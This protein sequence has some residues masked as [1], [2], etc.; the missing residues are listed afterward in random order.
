MKKCFT[1]A[2]GSTHVATPKN[3]RKKAFT[4]AEVL[5]TLGI[6]GVVAA[7]TIPVLISNYRDRQYVTAFKKSVSV[8]ANAYNL[9]I[10]ENGGTNDFGYL[11]A[12]YV[13][14]PE[15][16]GS[17][18]YNK[19]SN[20]NSD[21]LFKALSKHLNIIKDCGQDGKDG[22]FPET[23]YSP[24]RDKTWNIIHTQ[25]NSRRFFVLSD[26]TAVGLTSGFAYIDT[27][28]LKKPN[29]LGVDVFQVQFGTNS[30]SFYD[31]GE[32]EAVNCYTNEFTCSGWVMAHDNIDY[33]H[34]SDLNWKSKTKCGN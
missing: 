18:V 19:N 31:K 3:N 15:S 13:P 10:Y 17:G 33:T 34:C 28:G 27:N 20:I 22:C 9:A 14:L 1:L 24:F 12:E 2:E 25:G 11:P 5:I 32:K 29:K 23:I 4:L 26:G 30:L 6:I 7:M 21:I 8:L 16:E